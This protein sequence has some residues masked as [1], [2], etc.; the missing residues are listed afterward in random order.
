MD[1]E[2]WGYCAHASYSN[3]TVLLLHGQECRQAVE[4]LS[5]KGL[6]QLEIVMLPLQ[7]TRSEALGGHVLGP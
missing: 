2:E 3:G 4:T 6:V 1:G 7:S 5:V